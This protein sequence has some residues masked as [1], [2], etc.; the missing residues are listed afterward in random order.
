MQP[1]YCGSIAEKISD[2]SQKLADFIFKDTG[3]LLSAGSIYR[4]NGHDFLR[5]NV[6]C[7][8]KMVADALDRLKRSIDDFSN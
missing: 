2:D 4:G 6:A 8:R 5:M 1:T 7:P 3:L